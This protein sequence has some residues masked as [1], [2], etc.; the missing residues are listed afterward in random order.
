MRR[1]RFSFRSVMEDTRKEPNWI[2]GIKPPAEVL[3]MSMTEIYERECRE[4]PRRLADLLHAYSED[5]SILAEMNKLE[6]IALTPGPILFIGMGASY[7]SSIA[8]SVWMQSRGRS[9]FF[10]D[11]GEWLHYSSKVW[12]QVGGSILTTASGES[13]ELVQLCRQ[14]RGKP[15]ALLCNNPKS[16][17]WSLTEQ[18]LPMLAGPEYGNATKTYTNATAGSIVLA[19]HITGHAWKTSAAQMLE[20]YAES[21][22]KAF[23]LR[24]ELEQF[25]EGATNIELV[26]RGPA[27]GAAIMGALCIREMTGKRAAAHSGAGFRHGP[28]LDV[29]ETHLAIIIALGHTSA[30]GVKLAQD[31]NARNGKVM[32]I[33]SEQHQATEKLLPVKLTAVPEPWEAVTSVLVPQALTLGMIEKHGANLR[34][35]FEYG[36]M[37]E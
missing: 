36:I 13:A 3:A 33:S 15:L 21:L 23:S 22:E 14:E 26:G 27:Y 25:C 20:V 29:N 11:A 6:Q 19:S 1:K 2:A 12:T 30:L 9:S 32:L 4:Q 24:R 31:C 18:R 7:C 10:V 34:P 37:K 28:I 5:E 35:R 8:G 16:P 17:C